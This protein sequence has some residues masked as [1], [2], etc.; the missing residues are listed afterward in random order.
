MC[1][2]GQALKTVC[3]NEKQCYK[4]LSIVKVLIEYNAVKLN[5]SNISVLSIQVTRICQVQNNLP[6]DDKMSRRHKLM[7]QLHKTTSDDIRAVPQSS[8]MWTV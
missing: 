3:K 4:S 7:P 2:K 6:Q 8:D 5:I 1:N